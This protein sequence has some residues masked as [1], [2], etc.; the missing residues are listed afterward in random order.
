M[1]EFSISQLI[2]QS[3]VCSANDLGNYPRLVFLPNERIRGK[4]KRVTN[5]ARTLMSMPVVR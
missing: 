3:C 5:T 4:K 2:N 1:D